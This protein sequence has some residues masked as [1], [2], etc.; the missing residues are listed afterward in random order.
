MKK[1]FLIT[2]L[3]LLFAIPA[4]AE[5]LNF[6]ADVPY[7]PTCDEIEMY[8]VTG[9]VSTLA[10]SGTCTDGA[11]L[12]TIAFTTAIDTPDCQTY[13]AVIVENGVQSLPSPPVNWCPE[14]EIPVQFVR[15]DPVTGEIILRIV[16]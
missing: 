11:S 13:Y 8:Q 1:K 10:G 16:E 15:P 3:L 14:P 5:V 4:A 12:H 9:G 6:E 7:D 2:I